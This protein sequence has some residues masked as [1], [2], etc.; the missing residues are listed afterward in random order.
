M[1]HDVMHSTV[2][3]YYYQHGGIQK[4]PTA[5][6]NVQQ[7]I[8]VSTKDTFSVPLLYTFRSLKVSKKSVA[9]TSSRSLY[10]MYSRL[11]H[12]KRILGCR[13]THILNVSTVTTIYATRQSRR[14]H[15]HSFFRQ[16]QM[17]SQGT[18]EGTF[19]QKRLFRDLFTAT[20][21]Q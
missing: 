20:R 10:G 16:R 1:S 5:R 3:V 17:S 6:D 13:K 2:S 11:V 21:Q 19:G 12:L 7:R 9:K 4:K 14:G 18:V 8:N 15:K